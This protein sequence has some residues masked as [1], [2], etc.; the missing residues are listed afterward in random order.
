MLEE[1]VLPDPQDDATLCV[2]LTQACNL[3]CRYCFADGGSYGQPA[4]MM[5]PDTAR[6]TVDFLL[7][8]AG[9]HDNLSLSFFGGEPLLNFGTMQRTVEYASQQAERF[10]KTFRFNVTTNG[11]LLSRPVRRFLRERRFGVIVS[12]D[13]P[14]E[15]H[16][17]MRP[18]A[19]GGGSYDTIRGY[20]EA[21]Q[22]ERQPDEAAWTLRATFSR[23][24]LHFA[25]QVLHLAGLGFGDISVEPCT[26]TD[27]DLAIGWADLPALKAEYD[28]FA[29]NYLESIRTGQKFSFFHFRVT[30][31]QARRGTQR[32][33]QC[34]AG[35]GYLAVS[36]AGEL[37]PCHRLVGVEPYQIGT[38]HKGITHPERRALFAAAHVNS[39]ELCRRCWARYICGGGCHACA[40]Q[41]NG[42]IFEPYELECELVKHRIELGACLYAELSGAELDQLSVL[43]DRASANRPHLS[44]A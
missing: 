4:A 27:P 39:K 42:D 34:G 10:G 14:P 17:A 41:F 24:H 3:R 18:Y 16:D 26:S 33:A 36:A 19:K 29:G 43:Y 22:K 38:V 11:T 40:I 15:V 2:N 28:E 30:I 25:D 32:L 1:H 13:G 35:R 37:Y 9:Q 44:S 6:R 8:H 12:I 31:E 5:T 20:L 7:Q 23:Q 21:S